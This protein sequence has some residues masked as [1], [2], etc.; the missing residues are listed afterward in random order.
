M[1]LVALN[2][3]MRAKPKNNKY[4]CFL[5]KRNR[6]MS[7]DDFAKHFQWLTD[8]KT[9]KALEKMKK[10]EKRIKNEKIR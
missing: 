9:I 3:S 5:N 10:R 7:V 1:R 4:K 8:E 6:T 2:P